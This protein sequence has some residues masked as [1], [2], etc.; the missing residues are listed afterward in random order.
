MADVVHGRFRGPFPMRWLN[1]DERV[2]SAGE[3]MAESAR[4]SECPHHPLGEYRECHHVGKDFV[5]VYW[6]KRFKCWVS[7]AGT[8]G[9]RGSISGRADTELPYMLARLRGAA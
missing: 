5:A 1:L 8:I 7:T 3:G 9:K 6:D 2:G 4:A